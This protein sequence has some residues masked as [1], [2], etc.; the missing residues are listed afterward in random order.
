MASIL[1]LISGQVN[2]VAGNVN[3][4]ANIKDQVLGGL[5]NSILGSLTQTV[6]KPGGV[7]LIQQLVTGK[8]DAAKSPITALATQLFSGNVLK[9]LNL[10]QAGNSLLALVPMVMGRLGNII[11]DQDGDGDIDF[12]DLIIALKG[13][14]GSGAA[15][16]AGILGAAKGI[17]GSLLGGK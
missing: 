11:K 12:N 16:G 6:A 8:A 2:A 10:G 9:K 17:L 15:S 13:G 3:I 4:P 1:D 7:D 14:A 5:S